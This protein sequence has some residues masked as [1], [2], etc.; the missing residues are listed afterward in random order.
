MHAKPRLCQ[1]GSGEEG[2]ANCHTGT[3]TQSFLRT[4][5]AQVNADSVKLGAEA[6]R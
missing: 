3:E 4:Q 6:E 5:I 1:N 2:R